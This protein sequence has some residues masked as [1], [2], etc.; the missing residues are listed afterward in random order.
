MYCV[1][2]EIIHTVPCHTIPCWKVIGNYKG[3][4]KRKVQCMKLKFPEG[5]GNPNQKNF[6]GGELWIFSGT[7]LYL[8]VYF[9][10]NQC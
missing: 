6:H 9:S 10:G 3:E 4:I 5:W 8:F 2:T 1:I 7:T